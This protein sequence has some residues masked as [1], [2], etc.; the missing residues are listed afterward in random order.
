MELKERLRRNVRIFYG[1]LGSTVLLGVSQIGAMS[2]IRSEA[3]ALRAAGVAVGVLGLVPWLAVLVV[4]IRHGD[5]YVRRMHLIA[6]A[7]AAGASLMLLVT[8]GWLV[9]AWFIEPPD[10]MLIWLAFLMMWLVALVGTKRY[11]ERAP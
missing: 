2:L 8:V 7:M 5:E 10:F 3:P 6:I 1:W 4:I 9:R 11:F